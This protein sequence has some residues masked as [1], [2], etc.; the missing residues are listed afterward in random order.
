VVEFVGGENARQRSVHPEETPAQS[1]QDETELPLAI[2]GRRPDPI[3]GQLK[4]E[5]ALWR[6]FLGDDIDAILRDKD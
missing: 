4:A 2:R 3:S 1:R 6:A 5:L